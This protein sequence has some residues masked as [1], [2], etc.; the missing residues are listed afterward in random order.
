[1]DRSLRISGQQQCRDP[2]SISPASCLCLAKHPG[3]TYPTN[4]SSASAQDSGSARDRA[5]SA[6]PNPEINEG[7]PL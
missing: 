4:H 7:Y 1:M 3:G 6:E 2:L 5:F